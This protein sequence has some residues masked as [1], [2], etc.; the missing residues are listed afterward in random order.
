MAESLDYNTNNIRLRE[1]DSTNNYAKRLI[2]QH[3][4]EG[5][6]LPDCMLISADRQ[7]AGRGRCGKSFASPEGGSIYMTLIL[8]LSKPPER[9]MLI[10]PAAAVGTL[11]ALE[12]AGS[13]T[14]GIKWVNDLYLDGGKVCGILTEAVF[15]GNG[16]KVEYVIV[17]I[18]I[19]IDTDISSLPK[20]VQEVAASL[21]GLKS[22]KEELTLSIAE[23]VTRRIYAAVQGDISFMYTYR[24]RSILKGRLISWEDDH[25]KHSG[26]V[27]TINDSGGLEVE[28]DGRQIVL[29]SGEV[30]VRMQP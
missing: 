27:I 4:Q 1:I 6:K 2:E 13:K 16:V 25:G 10:T 19:N 24:E 30:S 7:S 3:R 17:G 9:C 8:R 26:R 29:S 21:T 18:G 12:T 22:S 5:T 11:E 14:L 15:D 28:E 23:Q 20:E